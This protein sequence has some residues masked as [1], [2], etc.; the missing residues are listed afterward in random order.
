[1]TTAFLD[2][3]AAKKKMTKGHYHI[4]GNLS[5]LIVMVVLFT[6]S[7]RTAARTI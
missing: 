5:V 2:A 3:I 6:D 7:E 4:D 1:M